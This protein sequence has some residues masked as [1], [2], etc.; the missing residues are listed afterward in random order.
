MTAGWM[1]GAVAV[2]LLILLVIFLWPGRERV[3]PDDPLPR[4]PAGEDRS[5]TAPS[6]TPTMPPAQGPPLPVPE[7]PPGQA[8]ILPAPGPPTPR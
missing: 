7:T 5:P 3:T 8:P 4:M 2:A 6:R 1:V